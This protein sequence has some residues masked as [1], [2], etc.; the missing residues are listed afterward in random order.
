MYIISMTTLNVGAR[1]FSMIIL[2][3][4]SVDP[5]LLLYKTINLHLAR[6][7]SK[8]ATA[9]ALGNAIGGTSNI[10]A[11]YLYYSSPH[12]YAAFGALM[13]AAV[14]LACTV[15]AYRW[16]VRRENARLDSGKPEEIAKVVKGGVTEEMVQMGWR[17][18]MY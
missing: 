18:E 6:P 13:G 17:Y 4:A 11:S 5:Q 3:F 10:W 14:L 16:L 9:S 8:R 2:P 15:T 12:F 1:Y 7:I